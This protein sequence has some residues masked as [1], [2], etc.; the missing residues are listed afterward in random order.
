[1]K[2]VFIALLLMVVGARAQDA[3]TMAAQQATMA[4]QQ[5][6]QKAMQDMMTAGQTALL[7]QQQIDHS[8]NRHFCRCRSRGSTR[9]GTSRF[10]GEIK[11]VPGSD[12]PVVPRWNI[13]S[14][15]Y[16]QFQPIPIA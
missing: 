4:A 14:Q 1:V 10:D 2:T 6:G 12:L 8:I 9:T 15:T 5:A 11:M 3:A 16:R 7:V 13:Q